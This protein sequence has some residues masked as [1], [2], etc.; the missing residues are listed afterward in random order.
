MTATADGGTPAFRLRPV[1]PR[2]L[3]AYVAMRCD[4]AMTVDLSGPQ[5]VEEM[6]AKVARDVEAMAADRDWVW[7]VEVDGDAGADGTRGPRVAGS[8]ALW[9]HEEGG[10]TISEIGWMVLTAFQGRGLARAAVRAVLDLAREDGR[11]G[12]VHAYPRV[13]NAASNALCRSL[14]F[15]L[16]GT[17]EFDY[18]GVTAASHH[19]VITP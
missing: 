19:W 6:P 8:V 11:W 2:D 10:E 16:V 5:P 4:P 7:M 14:G 17:E 3:D 1:G 18:R 12:P 15:A 9:A 13:S